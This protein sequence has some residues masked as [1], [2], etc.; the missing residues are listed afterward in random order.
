M[1]VVPE[2]R[3]RE[4]ELPPLT[5]SAVL[6]PWRIRLRLQ[7]DG[8]LEPQPPRRATK[9]EELLAAALAAL[10]DG[11]L[12]EH[13]TGPYYRLDFYLP[14]VKLAVEVDGASH[15]GREARERDALR[16]AWHEARGIRTARVS[17]R[18]VLE[19]LDEV[20]RRLRQQVLARELVLAAPASTETTLRNEV[21]VLAE[22]AATV[23]AEIK[24][25]AK[26]CETVLPTLPTQ[27]MR[28]VRAMLR[29]IF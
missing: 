14:R 27:R 2:V 26:A 16:D 15:W 12:R 5:G 20:V 29:E 23:E 6:D 21:V 10:D 9:S 1:S 22:A 24:R 18:E 25:L 13:W 7:R 19:S 11:W 3:S 28:L 4:D 8:G 17:D